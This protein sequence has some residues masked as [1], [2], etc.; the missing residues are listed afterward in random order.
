MCKDL[1]FEYL[2]KF[3]SFLERLLFSNPNV[4]LPVYFKSL[5]PQTTTAAPRQPVTSGPKDTLKSLNQVELVA[6]VVRSLKHSCTVAQTNPFRTSFTAASQH[7]SQRFPAVTVTNG[8]CDAT[9]HVN[10]A[11]TSHPLYSHWP[12]L[13]RHWAQLSNCS[14]TL[15]YS[16]YSKIV[17]DQTTIH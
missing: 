13:T 16:N 1:Q 10:G 17:A 15:G 3:I 4:P 7:A 8:N 6:E 9:T 14:G 5:V 11:T 2:E 12:R